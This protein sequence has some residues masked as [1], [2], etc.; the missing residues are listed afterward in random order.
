MTR[1]NSPEGR[2]KRNCINKWK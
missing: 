2:C 1:S